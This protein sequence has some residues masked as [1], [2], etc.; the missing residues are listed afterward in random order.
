MEHEEHAN[1]IEQAWQSLKHL[2]TLGKSLHASLAQYANGSLLSS[3]LLASLAIVLCH[4]APLSIIQVPLNFGSKPACELLWSTSPILLIAQCWTARLYSTTRLVEAVLSASIV[5][6]G[7][8]WLVLILLMINQIVALCSRQEQSWATRA[9][10]VQFF[11][12][13]LNCR[14]FA[15]LHSSFCLTQVPF[16]QKAPARSLAN[17]AQISSISR[18]PEPIRV[19]CHITGHWCACAPLECMLSFLHSNDVFASMYP[20]RWILVCMCM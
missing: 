9:W 12:P 14:P 6:T 17:Q 11:A 7:V 1:T 4:T 18:P 3:L 20:G 5:I 13:C 19:Y 15:V 8:A 2:P 10:D 16:S